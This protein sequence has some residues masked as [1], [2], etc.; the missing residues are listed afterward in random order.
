MC[1]VRTFFIDFTLRYCCRW[2]VVSYVA[3][4]GL[5]PLFVSF[6]CVSVLNVFYRMLST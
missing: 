6:W 3:P 4:A 5:S 1:D 2:Y